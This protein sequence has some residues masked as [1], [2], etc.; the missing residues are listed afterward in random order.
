MP[1]S[2]KHLELDGIAELRQFFIEKGTSREYAKNEFFIHRGQNLTYIGFILKG[3]FRYLGYSSEGKEQILGYSFENDFV[4]DYA[5]FQIQKPPAIDAQSIKGSTVL[6]L[7]YDEFNA[8]YENYRIYNL[9]SS[10]AETLLYDI[11]TRLLSMYCDSP[12]ERYTKLL[13]RHPDILTLV[14]I[15]EIASLIK[16]AP[17][18][19]SRIRKKLRSLDLDQAF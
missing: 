9:R 18:T 1:L 3:G 8:F 14:S 10:V 5:T 6:V 19:L 4:V 7:N 12:E 17:E 15:K 13:A 2:K 11:S 16:V